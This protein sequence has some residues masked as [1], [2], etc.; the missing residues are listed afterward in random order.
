MELLFEKIAAYSVAVIFCLIVVVIYLRK[1][2]RDSKK[3]EEK[4]V[5]AKL[6]GMYEPVSLHPGVDYQNRSLYCRLS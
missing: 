4:I 1:Q 6:E 3:V 2:K 5:K